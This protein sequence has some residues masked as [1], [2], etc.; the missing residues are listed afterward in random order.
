[1]QPQKGVE[2]R[3]NRKQLV[4]TLVLLAAID[5]PSGTIPILG[6]YGH[7]HGYGAVRRIFRHENRE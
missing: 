1:M 2:M 5:A 7:G 3:I 4:L 6:L